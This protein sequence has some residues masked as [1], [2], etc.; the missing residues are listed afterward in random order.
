MQCPEKTRLLRLQCDS[1]LA[2][3]TALAA[4]CHLPPDRRIGCLTACLHKERVKEALQ[5]HLAEHGCGRRQSRSVHSGPSLVA[6]A[7]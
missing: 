5:R 6:R 7:S 1:I 4:E 2:I 3:N